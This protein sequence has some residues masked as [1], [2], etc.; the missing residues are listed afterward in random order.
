[1]SF[2]P[3]AHVIPT[4]ACAQAWNLCAGNYKYDFYKPPPIDS[5]FPTFLCWNDMGGLLLRPKQQSAANNQTR[6]KQVDDAEAHDVFGIQF[7]Y[8]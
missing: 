3:A 1:M 6:D 4:W 7:G 5:R 2:L 8:G